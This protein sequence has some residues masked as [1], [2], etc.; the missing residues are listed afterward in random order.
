MKAIHSFL[1][2]FLA[3]YCINAQS[4]AGGDGAQANPYQIENWEQLNDIRNYLD[5]HFILNNSLNETTIGYTTY[6]K[7]GEIVANN[8]KAWLPI[9]N[10]EEPFT[11]SFNANDFSIEDL[12]IKRDA[13]SYVGL[14]GFTSNALIQNLQMQNISVEGFDFTAALVGYASNT[15]IDNV[16]IEGGV[17]GNSIVGGLVGLQRNLNAEIMHASYSGSVSGSE[18]VGGLVGSNFG[19]IRSSSAEAHVTGIR[20]IGGLVGDNHNSNKLN[21]LISSI[22]NGSVTKSPNAPYYEESNSIELTA[23]PVESWQFDG[24]SGDVSSTDNPLIINVDT[25]ISITANFFEQNTFTITLNHSVFSSE[26]SEIT[27]I[28]G[29]PMPPASAPN[30]YAFV[31]YF[32]EPNGQGQQ[33]YDEDMN[34]MQNWNIAANTTLYAAFDFCKGSPC[35]NGAT[36]INDVENLTFVCEC[37]EDF[38]GD[39]CQYLNACNI[40]ADDNPCGD[41]GTCQNDAGGIRCV[42]NEE[43]ACACCNGLNLVGFPCTLQGLA[44]TGEYCITPNQVSNAYNSMGMLQNHSQFKQTSF[45]S[46]RLKKESI[47]QVGIKTC[48][49]KVR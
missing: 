19:E 26:T 47:A 30:T 9:G 48:L 23:N 15:K 29:Q 34:S 11:G 8:G 35:Q 28:L 21:V 3:S 31:G 22:G 42:C 37:T 41:F 33:Y 14:F 4:F 10:K 27:A 13:Q 43:S 1:I 20:L 2:Y 24:W 17:E 12:I 32:S 44:D 16:H 40:L 39:R 45:A 6:V 25:D 36:C 7:D 18:K 38:S 49:K 46:I 5:K